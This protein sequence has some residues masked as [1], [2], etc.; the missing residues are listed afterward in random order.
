TAMVVVSIVWVVKGDA[1]RCRVLNG[2]RVDRITAFL[3]SRGSH[4]DPV[5]L[6][7]NKAKAFIGC[8]V[9]GKGFLFDDKSVECSPVAEMYRI[10]EESP[11]CKEVIYPYIGGEEVL[12]SPT[13]QPHRYIIRFGSR[14]ETES[15]QWQR[16]FQIVSQKVRPLREKLSN[17]PVDRA[18][19]Q[20]WW[21]F[22]NDRPELKEAVRN[23]GR[24]L[25]IPRVSQHLCVTFLPSS[26][27]FSDQ[28]VVVPS[29]T[30]ALLTVLQARVHNDW[31]WTFAS[32][33]GDGLRYTPT[34]C[35][36][37]FP[38]P[39]NY[40]SNAALE[41]VGNGYYDFRAALMVKNNEGLTKTYNRFHNPDERSPDIQKLRELHAQMDR[42][43][44]DAY[45]WSDVQ[46]VYDFRVQLDECIRLTWGE[47]LRDEV[48]ARLLELNRVRAVQETKQVS[49]SPKKSVGRKPRKTPTAAFMT[50]IPKAI[51]S[52]R[53]L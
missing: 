1:P 6:D 38:F 27:V 12:M 7:E 45:G 9:R 25:V 15:Q 14:T 53:K 48:L 17:S 11:E 37:T 47:D 22:G 31:T 2:K 40:E 10:L 39:P 4:D 16:P 30:N 42:V 36:E 18:H 5:H 50:K 24:V 23:R 41:S 34:D 43:V 3:S 44:L 26:L 21:R 35:F 20:Y 29:S 46:P 13:H 33:L 8:F 32:T 51:T 49:A 52:P 28:L 19:K